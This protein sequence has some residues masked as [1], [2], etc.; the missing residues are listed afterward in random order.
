MENLYI[1]L[2]IFTS[3]A[4]ICKHLF[5][6]NLKLPPS[7]LA[8]PIL[9]H[10]HL[11]KKGPPQQALQSLSSKFGPLLYLK[12]GFW[13]F[14]VVSSSSLAEECFTKNDVIFANRPRT[15]SGDCLTYDYTAFVWTPYGD[16]WRVLRRLSV[17]ELFSLKGLQKFS[18]TREKET[19]NVI[20]HLRKI[21]TNGHQKVDFKY[22]FSLLTYNIIMNRT[23]H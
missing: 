22:W 17:V 2:A 23:M 20:Y 1:Y 21:S 4:L 10:I 8:L 12:L 6:H 3:L 9:G 13:P 7:P 15:V 5:Y 14:L 16:L 18:D 19:R 11:I